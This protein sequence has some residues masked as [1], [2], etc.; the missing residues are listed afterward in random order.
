MM[1]SPGIQGARNAHPSGTVK[2]LPSLPSQGL[3]KNLSQTL[4]G[5]KMCNQKYS[6]FGDFMA[7]FL[8]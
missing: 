1:S 8:H 5:E 2:S 7:L 3:Q 4:L 6:G